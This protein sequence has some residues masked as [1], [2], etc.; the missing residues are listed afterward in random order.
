MSQ[1]T[2]SEIEFCPLCLSGNYKIVYR[3]ILNSANMIV[4]CMSC[5]HY[6]TL[7]MSPVDFEKL[8]NDKIYEVVE[9]RKSIFDKILTWEYSRVI[10]KINRLKPKKGSLLDFGSG[11]GKLGFIAKENGWNINCVETS[12][13]RAEYAKKIYGLEV[14]TDVYISGKIFERTF[15]VLT[16]FHV[17]EHLPQP[18]NLLRELIKHNL[19]SNALIVIEVPNYKSWQSEIAGNRWLHLDVPRHI[20]H[21]SPTTLEK[22]A[23]DLGMTASSSNYFSVHLGV[24]GMLD[25]ILKL[26]GYRK[27]IIY[28]L[29]NKRPFWL[30]AGIIVLLPISVIFEMI[31]ASVGRGGIVRKYFL[32]NAS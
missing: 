11:K 28:Q 23:K 24:L 3:R 2:T 32:L 17:V 13:D 18:K 5:G 7:L 4:K 27:N 6:Y 14:S 29:K 30:I 8:Y 20:N 1:A 31:A 19:K 26:F 15:D 12:K 16:L 25:S 10:K 22:L 9:N 21:F